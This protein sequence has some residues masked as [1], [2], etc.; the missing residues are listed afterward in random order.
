L[1]AQP[2]YDLLLK[3]GHVIDP[4]NGID[5]IMDFGISGGKIARVAAGINSSEAKQTVDVTGLYVTPGLDGCL[6][7]ARL[8][9][10]W[11]AYCR[12]TLRNTGRS[13]LISRIAGAST[14]QRK[15]LACS[16]PAGT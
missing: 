15:R 1:S 5:R 14:T 10:N 4:K 9:A 8:R 12:R 2:R 16:Q 7:T 11:L 3:G 6:R 13:F